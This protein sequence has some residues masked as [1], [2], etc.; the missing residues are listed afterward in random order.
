MILQLGGA[1]F[2]EY[3]ISFN[4]FLYT[5]LGYQIWAN[6]WVC[7]NIVRLCYHKHVKIEQ[8]VN[9][10]ISILKYKSISSSFN[11]CIYFYP[12]HISL[13]YIV[14]STIL[15]KTRPFPLTLSRQ[16]FHNA[17][18]EMN[19]IFKNTRAFFFFFFKDNTQE[20]YKNEIWYSGNLGTINR[21]LLVPSLPF[22]FFSIRR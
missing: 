20:C 17:K 15:P 10:T 1:C 16:I 22:F 14:S 21:K 13:G 8:Y 7:Y 9:L 18:L 12:Y 19:L 11:V 6:L 4:L 2:L 3:F 5:L